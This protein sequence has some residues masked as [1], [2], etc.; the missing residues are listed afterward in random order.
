MG[1]MGRRGVKK[2]DHFEIFAVVFEL[3]KKIS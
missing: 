3:K 2:S 1:R